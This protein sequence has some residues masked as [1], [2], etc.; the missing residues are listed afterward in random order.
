MADVDDVAS[1]DGEARKEFPANSWRRQDTGGNGSDLLVVTRFEGLGDEEGPQG[2]AAEDRHGAGEGSK[3]AR[4]T[5]RNKAPPP[6]R[7]RHSLAGGT[8]AEHRRETLD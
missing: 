5:P 3:T 7:R 8:A 6:A 2:E 1:D 4:V